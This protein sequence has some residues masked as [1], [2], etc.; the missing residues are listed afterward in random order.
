MPNWSDVLADIGER[1]AGGDKQAL[2]TV[3]REHLRRLQEYTGRNVIAYYSGWM[4]L[5]PGIPGTEIR[6]SDKNAFMTVVHRLDRK[7]GL[8]LL[9]HT[10]GGDIAATE[11]LVHYLREMFG[12]NIRA[13]VPQ[14][15]MS[16][17]TMVALSCREIVMGKQSNLGPIDPQLG[18]ISTPAVI[19]EFNRAVKEV[20]ENPATLPLW[21]TII[22]KY[23]PTFLDDCRR[24]ID[25]SHQMVSKWLA[26]NMF[27][28]RDDAEAAASRV[29]QR[30][31]DHDAHSSHS[32]HIHY[33]DCQEQE[34]NVV[35]LE[36]DAE[37][38]D[39]VLTLHHA[40]MH[41]MQRAAVVKMVENH[42]GVAVTAQVQVLR[43]A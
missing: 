13:V 36:E 3:R 7:L 1:E 41:T 43:T 24:S 16:A 37:L 29:V 25:W 11:S 20:Q 15:A 12:T 33:Q 31:G 14:I 8:D 38:Q 5:Q 32:R 30:F 34:L 40:Y 22:G 21:Q 42:L 10:P 17:G 4:D 28:G 35:M 27:S 23:H 2:D 18:G 9:L 39:R 26:S 19:S 6:D